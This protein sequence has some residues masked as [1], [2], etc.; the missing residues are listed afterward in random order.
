M[1]RV[2]QLVEWELAR[3]SLLSRDPSTIVTRGSQKGFS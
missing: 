3:W 1:E 2:Y